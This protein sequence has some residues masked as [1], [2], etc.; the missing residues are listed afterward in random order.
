MIENVIIK[1]WKRAKKV[2]NCEGLFC[3]WYNRGMVAQIIN[4]EIKHG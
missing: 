2:L 3:M 4:K 1:E